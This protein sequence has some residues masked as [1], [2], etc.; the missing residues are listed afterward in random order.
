M[1]FMI[2][3]VFYRT[4]IPIGIFPFLFVQQVGGLFRFYQSFQQVGEKITLSCFTPQ[5]D[6]LRL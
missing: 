3:S 2:I 6:D 1:P 4:L 5:V